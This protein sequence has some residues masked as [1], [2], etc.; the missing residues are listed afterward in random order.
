MRLWKHK[1]AHSDFDAEVRSHLQLEAD[2]LRTEGA[3]EEEAWAGARRAFGNLMQAQERF[4]ESG[5]WLWADRFMQDL[6][7]ASRTLRR[8]PGFTMAAVL[9]LALGIGA[10]T[11][12]FTLL[13]VAMFRTLP[14]RDPER[15]VILRPHQS[16]GGAIISNPVFEEI[17]ARQQVCTGLTAASEPRRLTVQWNGSG[18]AQRLMGTLVSSSYFRVL[19]ADINIGR[20]FARSD[21]DPAAARVAVISDGLWSRRFSRN[22]A[23]LGQTVFVSNQPATVIGVAP[24]GFEGETPGLAADVW[25]LLRQFRT[26]ED[27][28]NRLGSMFEIVGRLASG[29]SR[30]QAQASLTLL[31]Q[32]SLAA[33]F[34]SGGPTAVSRR[35]R[36]AAYRIELEEGGRGLLFLQAQF[37]RP[38]VIVMAIVALVLL[39]ACV[40]VANLL[41]ARAITRQ[42][43]IGVRLAIGSGRLRLVRQ[44]LT[45]SV[46]LALCGGGIG[47]L[48]AYGGG[49]FLTM[50]LAGGLLPLTLDLSPDIRVL[51]FTGAVSLATGFLFGLVPALQATKPTVAASLGN[52]ARAQGG[53]RSRQRLAKVLVSSQMAVS[54]LLLITAGLLVNSVRRMHD[55]DP[56]FDREGVLLVEVHSDQAPTAAAL[57]N[58]AAQ[59]R[60]RVTALPGVRSVSCSWLPLFDPFTDLSAPLAI[61]GYTPRPG[62]TVLARYNAVSPGY[63]ETVGMKLVAGREFTSRDRENSPL[64]VVVNERFVKEYFGGQNPLGKFIAIAVGPKSGWQPREIVGIARDAKYN[65]LR[66]EVKPLFYAPLSQVVRPVQSIEVRTAD[67]INSSA[68][69]AGLRSAVSEIA[70]QLVVDDV[71]TVAQQVDRPIATERLIAKL[72]AGFGLLALLLAGVGLYGVLTYAV[73]RRTGEIGI[74]MALGASR[75]DLLWFVLRECLTLV[76]AGAG[77]GLLLAMAATRLVSRFLYGLK[78]TDPLTI[79]LATLV[80]VAVATLAGYFPAR[81]ASHMDPLAALRYE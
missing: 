30:A 61:D 43:E 21:D 60:E 23:V 57:S 6:R 72:S 53:T 34:A 38:L 14:V 55:I 58:L 69:G 29:I 26:A 13:D 71:R 7:Y 1:R 56:G 80:L 52:Q 78:A 63:F 42:H 17:Q 68:L 47:L 3:G 22:P 33:E 70:P 2:R 9:S 75:M 62:E 5:R 20:G 28:R 4:Y 39:V 10:N 18:P 41:L 77:C 73:A 46:L 54:L 15:L 16:G 79:A 51:V 66:R 40:N 12:I 64:V 25:V 37:G 74:R 81:R 50:L 31:Y 59:L 76:I 11:A 44:L 65:D 32:Q 35:S 45:E 36:P 49:R 48:L 67:G 8:S 19:G 27:L 24:P